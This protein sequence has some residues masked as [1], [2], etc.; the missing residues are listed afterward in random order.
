MLNLL[1]LKV[2][3]FMENKEFKKVL[4]ELNKMSSIFVSVTLLRQYVD[5]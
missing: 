4:G 2:G 5:Y 3:M 1:S